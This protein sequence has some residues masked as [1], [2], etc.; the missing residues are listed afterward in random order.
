MIKMSIDDWCKELL[1]NSKLVQD[2]DDTVAPEEAERRFNR[3]VQLVDMVNGKETQLVFQTLVDVI[4][5]PEDYGAYESIHN[6]LWKFSPE[7]F[8]EYFVGALPK[9]IRRMSRHDQVARFLC[10]LNGHGR[11][12]YLPAFVAALASA[13]RSDK[14]TILNFIKKNSEELGDVELY[15]ADSRI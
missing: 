14:K 6:A 8:A 11:R 2:D 10:P 3:F 13:S 4:R 7:Q 15:H 12:K 9:L 5:M 1:Q